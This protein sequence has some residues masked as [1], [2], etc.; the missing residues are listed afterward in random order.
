[1]Q[2]EDIERLAALARIELTDTESTAFASDITSILGYV[3]DINSI[4]GSDAVE[5]SVGPVFNVMREDA[6]PH[7]PDLYTA[8]LIAAAPEHVGRYIQVKKILSD[9]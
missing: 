7:E 4:T 3:S 8:D 2:K 1:M 6:A 9:S 5:K